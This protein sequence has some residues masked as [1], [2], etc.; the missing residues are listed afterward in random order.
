ML[1]TTIP[2]LLR[3][4]LTEICLQTKLI[5][6]D[7]MPIEAFLNKC[8]AS[9]SI[10]AIRQSIKLLQCLGALDKDESLT[11]LG[12]HLAEMPVD[13][14]YAKM[15]IYSVALKCLNP[16]LN[17]VSIL[18]MGDQIFILPIKPADRFRCHQIRRNFGGESLSDHFVMLKIFQVSFKSQDFNHYQVV[19]AF[20]IQLWSSSQSIP[21]G[22]S[23]QL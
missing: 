17:I 12:S 7:A 15:L 2:E 9:P 20:S 14:K 3:T 8:I 22:T 1:D 5:V 18:S 21:C 10:P 6:G 13:A 19:P 11:V 16:V 4:S 23:I